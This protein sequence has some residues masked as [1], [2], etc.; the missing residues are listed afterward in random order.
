MAVMW[1]FAQVA[2]ASTLTTTLKV[3]CTNANWQH[4]PYCTAEPDWFIVNDDGSSF[5]QLTSGAQ[6]T[7]RNVSN[8]LG[9]RLQRFQ[10]E[11]AFWYVTD[12]GDIHAETDIQALSIYLSNYH[13]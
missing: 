13:E 8:D 1:L 3:P 10:L 5:G 2:D 6:F 7:Q 12:K 9:V 4:S 11:E